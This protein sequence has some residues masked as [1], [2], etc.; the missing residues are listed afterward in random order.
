M[1]RSSVRIRPWPLRWVLGQ[2]SL[3][4]LSQGSFTLA[5]TSYLAIFVKYILA[6]KKIVII[7]I[8]KF[9]YVHTPFPDSG[10]LIPNSTTVEPVHLV[11]FFSV[12]FGI[13]KGTVEPVFF[14]LSNLG[15][16]KAYDALRG[17]VQKRVAKL[18]TILSP[19]QKQTC[20]LN[21]LTSVLNGLR[22]KSTDQ[23]YNYAFSCMFNEKEK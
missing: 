2:G 1:K 8:I 22:G 14:F 23:S 7:K 12:K 13:Q 3:L 15:S 6:K 16:K 9:V 4:P 19:L 21:F 5:S 17:G 11:L 18:S 20:V 10:Q